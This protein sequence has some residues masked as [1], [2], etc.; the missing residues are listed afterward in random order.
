MAEENQDFQRAPDPLPSWPTAKRAPAAAPAEPERPLGPSPDQ[1]VYEHKIAD[2]EK[3]LSKEHEQ[4]LLANF[5]A[6]Q[7]AATAARVEVSIK[8]LQD[9]LRRD[10]REAEAEESRRVM[11]L[12]V[13]ELEARLAQERETWV[14][15]LKS[16]MQTRESQDKDGESHFAARLQEMERRWL[17]EK[18]GWQKTL[19]AKDEENRNL[20][21]LAE[22]LKGADAALSQMAAEKKMLEARLAEA[23]QERAEATAKAAAAVEKEKE[24]IQLRA[25][26]G[27]A[28]QQLAMAQD[29]LE[30]DLQALRASYQ[31]RE[32][33]LA[34]DGERLQRESVAL[35]E[36]LRAE[37][38]AALR[39]VKMDSEA[40]LARH[41]E[42]AERAASELVRLRAV[43]GALERQA[44]AG[45]AQIEELKR[46]AV[47]WEKS[48]ERYKAEFAVLQ[49]K[50][51]ERE[52]EIRAE[53][54]AQFQKT[55]EAEKGLLK[56][57]AQE[58]F[59]QRA[60]RLSEQMEKEKA[61][62]LRQS[63]AALRL[64]I[65]REA[66]VRAEAAEQERA[67]ARQALEAELD[68]LRKEMARK[69]ADWAQKFLGRESDL[70][71]AR[72]QAAESAARLARIE[73]LTRAAA[74][75]QGRLEQ[76]KKLRHALEAEK[77]DLERLAAAQAA[78]VKAFEEPLARLREEM[79]KSTGP[80]LEYWEDDKA[81]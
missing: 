15:T 56:L 60:A 22:K 6:Q 69:D 67:K 14:A 32:Q 42:V 79:A 39:R 58:D 1:V 29:R 61:A 47:E 74:E 40:E 48:Q 10:R 38:E 33:R 36:R 43:C 7:E 77:A 76:E 54:A 78:Q 51:A 27:L 62:E 52:K 81:A 68:R 59:N 18:A 13:Q 35:G 34:L 72:S 46:G 11:D 45:R 24:A 4:L 71:S 21:A 12:K 50:W 28:R 49:R 8:D 55:L 66:L 65:G 57:Q 37:H 23:A 41:K 73:E 80:A 44:V 25:D 5:K 75:L 53:A 16:Q 26:L 20:R 3:R 9:K 30:R 2:L 17:E 64:E 63:E 31:E 19:L 70:V